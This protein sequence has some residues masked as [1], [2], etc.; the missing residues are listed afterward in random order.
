ML[1]AT[2][3]PVASAQEWAVAITAIVTCATVVGAVVTRAWR[4]AAVAL[5]EQMVE[6]IQAEVPTAVALE[7]PRALEPHAAELRGQLVEL[8][9][10]MQPNG[11]SSLRDQVDQLRS[12]QEQLGRQVRLIF[13][14]LPA[15]SDPDNTDPET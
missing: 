1:A 8:R 6:T 15:G 2:P 10:E 13:A 7:V 12:G 11:G 14:R 3:E 4:R 5:H 9:K